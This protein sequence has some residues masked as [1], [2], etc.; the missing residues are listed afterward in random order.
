MVPRLDDEFDRQH[1]PRMIF[2]EALISEGK[3]EIMCERDGYGNTGRWEFTAIGW[4]KYD[5]ENGKSCSVDPSNM[6][7]PK[8]N[9]PTTTA[10]QN[11]EPKAIAKQIASKILGDYIDIFKRCLEV[12]QSHQEHADKTANARTRLADACQDEREFRGQPM[13][14][15][16]VRNMAGDPLR[17]EFRSSGDVQMNLTTDEAIAVIALIREQ[18]RDA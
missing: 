7:N 13:R 1:I 14:Q 15:F 8:A 6:W 16:Y 2:I 10:N 18:R 12:A 3:L 9:R 5:D 4:P 11:R 17:V